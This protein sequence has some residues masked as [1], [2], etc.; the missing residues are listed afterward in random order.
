MAPRNPFRIHGVVTRPDFTDRESEIE[1]M[2][3]TLVE[4]GALEQ[5]AP[6]HYRFDS[7]FQRGW[8]VTHPLHDLGISLP[9]TYTG[10]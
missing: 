6:G 2:R 5:L 1:R 10:S 3:A 9:A 4:Q 7:P 8:V